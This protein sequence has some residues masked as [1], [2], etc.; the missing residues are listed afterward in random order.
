MW[1]WGHCYKPSSLC[2]TKVSGLRQGCPLPLILFMI[3]MD[4]ISGCIRVEESVLFGDLGIV[5]LI[6]ADDMVLLVLSEHDLQ[7]LLGWS[8]V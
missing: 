6:F 2:G 5:F 4:R 7:H 1:Y 8:E 3:F